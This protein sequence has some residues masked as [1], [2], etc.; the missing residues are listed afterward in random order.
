MGTLY[1]AAH[2]RRPLR[3]HQLPELPTIDLRDEDKLLYHAQLICKLFKSLLRV[4]FVLDADVDSEEA[5]LVILFATGPEMAPKQVYRATS[6]KLSSTFATSSSTWGWPPVRPAPRSA[7]TS[8]STPRS[9]PLLGLG[10]NCAVPP[11]GP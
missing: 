4:V 10:S 8:T 2:V 6:S 9:L 5:T 3:P 7:T 1:R 11:T